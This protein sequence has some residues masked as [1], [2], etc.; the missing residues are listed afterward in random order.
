MS[1]QR[2]VILAFLAPSRLPTFSGNWLELGRHTPRFSCAAEIVVEPNKDN[3]DVKGS[4]PCIEIALRRME[5]EP[6]IEDE[7]LRPFVMWESLVDRFETIT[8]YMGRH[9]DKDD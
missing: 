3:R 2:L 8:T 1:P 5:G 6:R 7:E 4:D 9:R